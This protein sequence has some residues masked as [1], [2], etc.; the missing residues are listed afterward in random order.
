MV[1]LI[2]TYLG[3]KIQFG[4]TTWTLGKAMEAALALFEGHRGPPA[5]IDGIQ[6]A[7]QSFGFD[8]LLGCKEIR[9]VLIPP[10]QIQQ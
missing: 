8:R 7:H 10:S 3:P 6:R 2:R 4:R 9:R 5:A 1:H